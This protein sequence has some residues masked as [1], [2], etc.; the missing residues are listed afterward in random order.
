LSP[1]KAY[2]Q[3]EGDLI[4]SVKET[5]KEG[6]SNWYQ[7]KKYSYRQSKIQPKGH[8]DRKQKPL[9]LRADL[10]NEQFPHEEEHYEYNEGESSVITEYVETRVINIESE[11][12]A[13]REYNDVEDRNKQI[14]EYLDISKEKYVNNDEYANVEGM[15]S[16]DENQQEQVDGMGS[17]D[18]DQ[19]EHIEGMG[20]YD[21]DQQERIEYMNSDNENQQDHDSGMGSDD[22][23]QRD[24]AYDHQNEQQYET[25]EE[26][27]N[28]EVY[29]QLEGEGEMVEEEI[30]HAGL[31]TEFIEEDSKHV[32]MYVLEGFEPEHAVVS[33]D[34]ESM[35]GN[36]RDFVNSPIQENEADQYSTPQDQACIDELDERIRL[37]QLADE[38]KKKDQG[39]KFVLWELNQIRNEWQDKDYPANRKIISQIKLEHH[40][41]NDVGRIRNDPESKAKAYDYSNIEEQNLPVHKVK[42]WMEDTESKIP[43]LTDHESAV[44][45]KRGRKVN[46]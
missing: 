9:S 40:W 10:L 7:F 32:M 44:K 4:N 45:R 8:S 1:E 13:N 20:S 33:V 42:R 23:N 39:R 37:F 19:H 12:E 14:D 35:D 29:E 3:A 5:P 43:M 38:V 27:K 28:H 2:H 30:K 26:R 34:D 36:F 11:S 17:Y 22:E 25:R 41:N 18:R 21:G 31:Q 46:K 15:N 16:Y 24:H 6:Q